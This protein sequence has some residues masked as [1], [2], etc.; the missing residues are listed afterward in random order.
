[1][2]INLLCFICKLFF[3][4]GLW[5]LPDKKGERKCGSVMV[6]LCHTWCFDHMAYMLHKCSVRVCADIDIPSCE[7][8]MLY[9]HDFCLEKAKG[10]ECKFNVLLALF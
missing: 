7:L 5:P 4:F 2:K 3:V 6:L 8:L 9:Y 10:G 1:M